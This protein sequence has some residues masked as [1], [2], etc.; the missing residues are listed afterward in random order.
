MLTPDRPDTPIPSSPTPVRLHYINSIGVP[1]GHY[2]AP[3]TVDMS[4]PTSTDAVM[5]EAFTD[6]KHQPPPKSIRNFVP[7]LPVEITT[8]LSNSSTGATIW[9]FKEAL[10]HRRPV[11]VPDCSSLVAGYPVRSGSSVPTS[12]V[13]IP[14]YMNTET[15]PG[16]VVILG[17][18][19]PYDE[20]Y[21]NF[22]VSGG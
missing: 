8:A 16:A 21:L 19:L 20:D 12:A 13:V 11:I 6:L 4:I 3:P 10:Q 2:S 7:L 9:P 18:R 5:A 22:I 17:V 15:L 1:V 14:A